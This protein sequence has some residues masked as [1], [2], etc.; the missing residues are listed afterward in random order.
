MMLLMGKY[1]ITGR[2]GSGKTTVIREL[3]DRGF[4]AY[5]TDD[6]EDVTKLEDKASG[7]IVP[8]PE[9]PVDWDRY[10]WNWQDE[11][12]RKLLSQE[13]DIFV[14]AIVGN[15]QNYYPLFDKIFALTLS[16]RTVADRLDTHEHPRTQAEKDKAIVAHEKKQVRWTE[17]GLILV[18]SERPVS[19]IV[20]DILGY[21]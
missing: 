10:T 11:A 15:Q 1:F 2:P 20:D 17:Q 13:G 6:L 4:S 18:S 7:E 16:G 3:Q 19:E 12:L 5:N 8:W 14:G 9:G 21:L